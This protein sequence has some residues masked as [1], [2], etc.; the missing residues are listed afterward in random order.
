MSALAATLG[1]IGFG[2]AN[3][4]AL[5]VFCLLY[6]PCTATIA[7][8]NREVHSKKLTFAIISFQLIVAWVMSFIVY[9]IGLLF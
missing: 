7:T 4:Y 9:R 3:A 6:V 2:T 1:G 5:M 8:I